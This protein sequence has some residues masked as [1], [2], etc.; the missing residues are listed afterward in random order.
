MKTTLEVQTPFQRRRDGSGFCNTFALRFSPLHLCIS[1]VQKCTASD[2]QGLI[3]LRIMTMHAFE[4]PTGG[5]A[6]GDQAT[7]VPVSLRAL[8]T[9]ASGR[10]V[11]LLFLN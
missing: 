7:L 10:Y 9:G 4:I 6:L 1:F 3:P 11:F 2:E 5:L 8:S